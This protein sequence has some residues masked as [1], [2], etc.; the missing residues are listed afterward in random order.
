MRRARETFLA[1]V[2]RPAERC[3]AAEQ[4]YW[5]ASDVAS[6]ADLEAHLQDINEKLESVL[7]HTVTESNL[8]AANLRLIEEG[9]L[10]AQKCLHICAQLSDHID[11]VQMGLMQHGRDS[12]ELIDSVA[13]LERVT[14]Q[15]LQECKESLRI[16]AGKLGKE[17]CCT[18]LID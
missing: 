13:L 2:I 18:R 7:A 14:S 6:F 16:T 17:S 8:D 3:A 4:E 10:S 11:R 15:G 12:S 9:R 1:L 5:F